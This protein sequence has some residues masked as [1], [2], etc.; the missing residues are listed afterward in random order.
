MIRKY[1]KHN[2]IY[3]ITLI[4]FLI[5]IVLK[6]LNIVDITIPCLFKTFF[7]LDCPGC[8]LT[9]ACIHLINFEF[10]EAYDHNS[11][12]FIIIPLSIILLIKNYKTFKY[13]H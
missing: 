6:S 11:I 2:I 5:S 4:F 1:L 8:G 3:V 13:Y 7:N 12:I 9:S 10:K